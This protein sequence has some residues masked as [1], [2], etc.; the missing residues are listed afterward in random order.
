MLILA[1]ASLAIGDEGRLAA[2]VEVKKRAT[3]E[4]SRAPK[5]PRSLV[6]A[7]KPLPLL[8]DATKTATPIVKPSVGD[9][10]TP[11]RAQREPA[12]RFVAPVDPTRSSVTQ[13]ES[14][15]EDTGQIAAIL[16]PVIRVYEPIRQPA[17]LPIL[18]SVLSAERMPQPK[19]TVPAPTPIIEPVARSVFLATR[20][21]RLERVA[22]PI[23]KTRGER[24]VFASRLVATLERISQPASAQ[25]LPG[26]AATR[27]SVVTRRANVTAPPISGV[28]QIARRDPIAATS[29]V[30]A[31]P[32]ELAVESAP[33]TT[34]LV[35]EAARPPFNLQPEDSTIELALERT[36]TEVVEASPADKSPAKPVRSRRVA[37]V[38][39]KQSSPVVELATNPIVQEP[40]TALPLLQQESVADSEPLLKLTDQ[41]L[42]ETTEAKSSLLLGAAPTARKRPFIQL[43]EQA[44]LLAVLQPSPSVSSL[45]APTEE[46]ALT[47]EQIA[48]AEEIAAIDVDFK[49]INAMSALTAPVAGELPKN[50]AAARFAR[51]GE[52][53]HR[54]GFSR[55]NLETTMMWEAP[56]SSHRPLYFED[57]NLER[58]GYK[59]PVFQPALSAAHFFGHLPL[60]PYMMVSDKHRDPQYTLG[61]YRPGDYAPY[62]L[63]VRRFRI[64]ASA[65]ELA[66]AAAFIFA[67]P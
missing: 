19:Q 4:V 45:P 2:I 63:Y 11:I 6:V 36:R 34:P 22:A 57:I 49:P 7:A 64:D 37:S 8:A 33:R 25:S 38:K 17:P 35:V 30:E 53:T 43:A 58:H 67:F 23:S 60:L 28:I 9:T 15:P 18:E 65:A 31:A 44:P 21:D 42:Q 55:A 29:K 3:T 5:E 66:T 47:E 46:P 12:V 13:P 26:I 40:T 54:M 20:T 32:R 56:A 24:D 14:V 1:G 39:K 62:S 52:V 16:A 48:E 50:Y 10:V 41:P 61:H 59:V 27:S 51:E